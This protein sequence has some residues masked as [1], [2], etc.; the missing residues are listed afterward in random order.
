MNS[1]SFT[2][3]R[4]RK[5]LEV[6]L[7]AIDRRIH[8]AIELDQLIV[9]T[10]ELVKNQ[11]EKAPMTDFARLSEDIESIVSRTMENSDILYQIRKTLKED[12]SNTPK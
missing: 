12:L 3:S 7:G 4:H 8:R 10:A 2:D 11:L 5:D 9:L 1:A 6:L